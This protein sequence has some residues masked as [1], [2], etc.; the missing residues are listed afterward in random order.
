M[1]KLFRGLINNDAILGCPLYEG[2]PKIVGE[3]LGEHIFFQENLRILFL[4]KETKTVYSVSLA[5][6]G[7]YQ[8]FQKK[9]LDTEMFNLIVEDS[10]NGCAILVDELYGFGYEKQLYD[11]VI[12]EQ[13]TPEDMGI[14]MGLY[15]SHYQSDEALPRT[16]I[17]TYD[18]PDSVWYPDNYGG[19]S[20]NLNKYLLP[21][22]NI[23]NKSVWG[24]NEEQ[25][26]Y[27]NFKK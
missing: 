24:V 10:T 18:T 8:Q 17:L 22:T 1:H 16:W 13:T 6:R 9:L 27:A 14:L 2:V 3:F 5:I 20:Y 26:A 7:A 21:A 25:M 4:L 15:Q 12:I 11:H 23:P 19:F